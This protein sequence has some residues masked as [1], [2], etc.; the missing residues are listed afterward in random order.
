MNMHQ[1][2]SSALSKYP[3]KANPTEVNG[4]PIMKRVRGPRKRISRPSIGG[5]SVA[6]SVFRQITR[7]AM[8]AMARPVSEKIKTA[9]PSVMVTLFTSLVMPRIKAKI[10]R[11][12][13]NQRKF[14]AMVWRKSL[15]SLK[16]VSNKPFFRSHCLQSEKMKCTRARSTNPLANPVI[17]SSG[18]SDKL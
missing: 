5:K 12:G 8:K 3:I 13:A 9:K 7:K 2:N 4:K 1:R 17:K 11:S 15:G 14:R 16:C 18:R 6:C 10:A